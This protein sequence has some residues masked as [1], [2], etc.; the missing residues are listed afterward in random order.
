MMMLTS[1]NGRRVLTRPSALRNFSSTLL[2]PL[3]TKTVL[4]VEVEQCN[5]SEYAHQQLQEKYAA[6]NEQCKG[7]L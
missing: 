1:V 3:Q 4:P 2:V 5:I 6:F 7:E